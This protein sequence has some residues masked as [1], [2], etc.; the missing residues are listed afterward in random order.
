MKGGKYEMKKKHLLMLVVLLFS[1]ITETLPSFVTAHAETTKTELIDEKFLNVSYDYETKEESTRWRI[2][3]SR[4]SEESDKEQRLKLKVTD[5]KGK[6]ITYP[7]IDDMIEKD[8]W[9]IEKNYSSSM[10]GQLVFDLPKSVKTL[11][12]DVQMDEQTLSDKQDTKTQENILDVKEPFVLKVNDAKEEKE[13]IETSDSKA[14][15][16][17]SSEDFIGPPEPEEIVSVPA[18]AVPNNGLLRMDPPKYTNKAPVY[19]NNNGLY[20]TC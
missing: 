17:T 9:L 6:V 16:K 18:T 12:L 2:T 1:F 20:P 19:T 8:E 3:F 11:N 15:V 5:E 13:E 14:A 7:T 10:E 4:Q